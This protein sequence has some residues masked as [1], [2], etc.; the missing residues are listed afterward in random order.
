MGKKQIEVLFQPIVSLEDR[1][2]IGFEA[3][4]RWNHPRL[5]VVSPGD[6]IPAAERSGL[7]HEL[8]SY[9]MMTA[10]KQFAGIAQRSGQSELLSASIFPAANCCGTTSST[11]WPMF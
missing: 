7:I 6:F 5:G 8:G 3:L 9:V 10:A 2:V 11:T 4:V 1:A